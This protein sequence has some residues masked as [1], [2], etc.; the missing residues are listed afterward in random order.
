MYV[1]QHEDVKIEFI[2]KS[3]VYTRTTYAESGGWYL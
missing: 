1:S 2:Q 3:K